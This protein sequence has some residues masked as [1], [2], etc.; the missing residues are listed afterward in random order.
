MGGGL[1]QLVAYGPQDIYLTGKPE[2]TYFKG[3]YKRHTNFAIES[4][5]Q[6]ISETPGFDKVV[7]ITMSRNGDL[8]KGLHLEYNPYEVVN[9]G[10]AGKSQQTL[11]ANVGHSLI[12]YIDLYIG[13]QLIDRQYGKWMTLWNYLTEINPTGVQ[14]QVN[15]DGSEPTNGANFNR[16]NASNAEKIRLSHG[17]SY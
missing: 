12:K 4:I 7:M 13:G 11:G 15:P 16:D 2:L 8:L 10:W 3:I 9:G 14:A 5:E 1:M 17:D 6:V